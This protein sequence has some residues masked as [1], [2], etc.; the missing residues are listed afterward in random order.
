MDAVG[1]VRLT[2]A[3]DRLVVTLGHIVLNRRGNSPRCSLD[4][5]VARL[6]RVRVIV[7]LKPESELQAVVEGL[8]LPRNLLVCIEQRPH[9][10]AGPLS[11]AVVTDV[12]SRVL[13]QQTNERKK[14]KSK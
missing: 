14:Q 4:V 9:V 6:F 12:A 8:I 11:A 7:L 5:L 10:V 13:C 2:R 1:A 3:T